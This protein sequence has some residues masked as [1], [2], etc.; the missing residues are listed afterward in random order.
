MKITDLNIDCLEN[1]C[2]FLGIEDLMNLYLIDDTFA[3]AIEYALRR[4]SVHIDANN[5]VPKKNGGLLPIEEF[6]MEH[7][8]NVRIV[9]IVGYK[10]LNKFVEKFINKFFADGQI[11]ICKLF[12]VRLNKEFIETNLMF[13]NSLRCLDLDLIPK[14]ETDDEIICIF[15][16][17]IEIEELKIHNT[18]AGAKILFCL[19]KTPFRRL[20]TLELHEPPG[21]QAIEQTN[22]LPLPTVRTLQLSNVDWIPLHQYFPNVENLILNMDRCTKEDINQL[23]NATLKLSALKSLSI[24]L[25]LRDFNE[26]LRSIGKLFR[27]RN[28]KEL[29][30]KMTVIDLTCISSFIEN[31]FEGGEM[32]MSLKYVKFIDGAQRIEENFFFDLI[33]YKMPWV[34]LWQQ[35]DDFRNHRNP[36]DYVEMKI[37]IS[38][39]E[40]T[41][42]LQTEW[43]YIAIAAK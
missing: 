19:L 5:L 10:K 39:F 18:N 27:L 25:Q 40:R 12:H 41:I 2:D 13:F 28:L 17:I 42:K 34:T 16:A 4:K 14:P 20:S 33:P 43:F 24:Q 22:L 23:A 36:G 35:F 7:G 6:F 21:M 29:S 38:G 26:N 37:F 11:K 30:F 9:E 8:E 31:S 3:E 32:D 15:G 1:I